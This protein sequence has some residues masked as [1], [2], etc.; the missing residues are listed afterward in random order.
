[1]SQE[2]QPN[3]NPVAPLPL[4]KGWRKAFLVLDVQRYPIILI[5]S[6]Y[7]TLRDI[8]PY[9]YRWGCLRSASYFPYFK[10]TLN[11]SNLL[12][13][14]SR[15]CFFECVRILRLILLNLSKNR[16][17]IWGLLSVEPRAFR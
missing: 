11:S 6:F 17:G 8:D 13:E 16:F 15:I 2:P 7:R 1:M 9:K 4:P 5:H 12:L 3:P 10:S 14:S